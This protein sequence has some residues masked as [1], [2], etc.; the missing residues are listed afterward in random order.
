MD[1]ALDFSRRI[2][3]QGMGCSYLIKNSQPYYPWKKIGEY[4]NQES[5]KG[6]YKNVVTNGSPKPL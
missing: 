2:K 4:T 6:T 3:L 5:K 1:G